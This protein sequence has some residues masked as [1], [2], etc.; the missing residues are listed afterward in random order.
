MKDIAVLLNSLPCAVRA[1]AGWLELARAVRGS[2]RPAGG[3]DNR[4]NGVN[5]EATG[6]RKPSCVTSM[7]RAGGSSR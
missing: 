3:V 1:A 6:S 7:N 2:R 5:V 4:R